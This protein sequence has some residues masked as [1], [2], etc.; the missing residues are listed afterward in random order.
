MDAWH[1][2]TSVTPPHLSPQGSV[3]LVTHPWW[4]NQDVW[5]HVCFAHVLSHREVLARAYRLR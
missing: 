1:M 4:S 3:A 5:G 2:V